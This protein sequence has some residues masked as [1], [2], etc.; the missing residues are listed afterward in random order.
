[1]VD[2]KTQEYSASQ[3]ADPHRT[4]SQTIHDDARWLALC[5]RTTTLENNFIYAVTTTGVFCRSS[6]SSRLPLRRNVRFFDTAAQA[7]RAGF[8]ACLRCHPTKQGSRSPASVTVAVQQALR[9]ME[10]HVGE[11]AVY[12]SLAHQ[13]GLS[14]AHFHRAFR[15]IVGITPKRYADG[16]R[17]QHFKRNLKQGSSVTDSLYSSGFS[18]SSRLYERSNDALGMVPASY[19][20]GDRGL[21]LS[22]APIATVLGPMLLA[23]SDRGVC[24]LQFGESEP[25]LFEALQREFPN[26]ALACADGTAHPDFPRWVETIQQFVDNASLDVAIPL[27]LQATAFQL[28]VWDYLQTIPVGQSRSYARAAQ[29]LGMP[30]STRAV[31][32][33]CA[34]NPVALLV[35]CHRVLRSN[36]EL[37]GYRW[38]L[39]RKRALLDR[40]AQAAR[41]AHAKPGSQTLAF[42]LQ[43]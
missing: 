42:P 30:T 23:A 10:Q 26:A 6:C 41:T 20:N 35:P 34:R 15:R 3:L 16:L 24:F 36:G 2:R 7:E 17:L 8:R 43:P 27:D 29:E 37:G 13:S 33:A 39:D 25:A 19:R 9:W 14:A 38:G 21:T 18:S 32:S 12:T 22:Y 28:R 11:P 31:A 1:M 5:D 40:E 4:P